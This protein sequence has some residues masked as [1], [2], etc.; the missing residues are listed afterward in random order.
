[1]PGH[2]RVGDFFLNADELAEL[3]RAACPWMTEAEAL[4]MADQDVAA[5]QREDIW[6]DPNGGVRVI[7]GDS[8]EVA[9]ILARVEAVASAE[10]HI[11]A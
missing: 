9:E 8:N 6:P 10:W 5:A 4:S 3:A 7:D 1:M 11:T 2:R